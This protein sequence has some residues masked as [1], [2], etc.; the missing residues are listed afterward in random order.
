MATYSYAGSIQKVTVSASGTYDITAYG[1]QGGSG[2]GGQAGGSGA[3]Y[4]GNF[5]LTAGEKLEVVTGGAGAAGTGTDGGGGGGGGSFV[6]ANTGAGG[7]YQLLLAAG[8]GGGGAQ[9]APGGAG[10]YSSPGDGSGGGETSGESGGGSGH[11]SDGANNGGTNITGGYSGGAGSG[12]YGGLHH[13]GY[14]GNGGFGGG[15]GGGYSRTSNSTNYQGGGGGGGGYSGGQGGA[16]FGSET[17]Y[18]SAG[19]GG[20]GTSFDSAGAPLVAGSAATENAANNGNGLVTITPSVACYCRGT[21]IRTAHGETVVEELKI[22]DLLVTASGAERPIKWIGHQTLNVAM[23]ATPSEAWPIEIMEGSFGGGLP[24]R[25]LRLSPGHPVLVRC[26]EAEVLVPIMCLING[27][28]VRRIAVDQVTYW[29]IELDQHDILLA[30]GLPAESFLDYGNRS[31]FENGVDHALANPDHVPEGLN[32]RCRPVA[33]DGPVV[34]A[35]R[36]RLDGLFAMRLAT[37]CAWPALGEEL[38]IAIL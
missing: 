36:R 9:A 10:G 14:G 37:H 22:G 7:S 28:S 5:N 25:P 18:G 19:S 4:G 3:E 11:Q 30:E 24:E 13:P 1:A 8:G 33:L 12:H 23:L 26:D 27:T 16:N 32:G 21:L 38:D 20:G 2:S 35:E 29:H 34:E 17:A 31:W 15:G 6:L